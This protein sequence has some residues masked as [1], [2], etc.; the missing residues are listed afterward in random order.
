MPC[1]DYRHI[2]SKID[3]AREELLRRAHENASG[4]D[5]FAVSTRERAARVSLFSA[6]IDAQFHRARCPQCRKTE[7]FALPELAEAA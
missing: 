4:A 5:E 6:E 3:L 7:A 2:Q 1:P